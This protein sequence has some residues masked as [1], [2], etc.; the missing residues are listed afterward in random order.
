MKMKY[1]GIDKIKTGQK[2]KQLMADKG[3]TPLDV[4]KALNLT[5]VQTT[6]HWMNGRSLPSIDHLLELSV[7]FGVPVDDIVCES[8]STEDDR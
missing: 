4:Q 2:I 3:L 6:Y 1:Q 5:V 8:S 7:L